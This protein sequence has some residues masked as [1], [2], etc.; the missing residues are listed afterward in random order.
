M[1]Y[2]RCYG[3]KVIALRKPHELMLLWH[4]ATYLLACFNLH[5]IYILPILPFAPLVIKLEKRHFP[6]FVF[7]AVTCCTPRLQFFFTA[8]CHTR[9][10][11]QNWSILYESTRYIY[12]LFH[13]L[14]ACTIF[15][16]KL[17]KTNERAQRV[18]LFYTTSE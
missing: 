7:T 2:P 4:R 13:G 9:C 10:S 5:K 18:S 14:W 16:H 1:Y 17:C 6:C 3:N 8:S 12:R 15:I 11:G